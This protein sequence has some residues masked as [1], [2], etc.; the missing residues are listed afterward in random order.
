[1]VIGIVDPCGWTETL[2]VLR[3]SPIGSSPSVIGCPVSRGQEVTLRKISYSYFFKKFLSSEFLGDRL[4]SQQR[5]RGNL[6][7]DQ[8]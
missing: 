4:P 5:A 7:K 8:L 6:E 1:M 3:I 2:E